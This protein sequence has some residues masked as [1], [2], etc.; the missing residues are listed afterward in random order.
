M[1]LLKQVHKLFAAGALLS[2]SSMILVVG[3]QIFSRFFLEITPHWTEEAARIFFIYSVA[4]GTGTA[5]NQGDFVRLDLV[6]KYLSPVSSRIL[7]F[8]TEIITIFFSIIL[9]TQSLYFIR[10]GMDEKSAA[11]QI[12]MSFIFLSITITGI[13]I[14]IFTLE[15]LYYTVKGTKSK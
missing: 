10:L 2:L 9:T 14:F 6:G 15:N 7:Q 8:F 4:F 5:I 1:R 12:P 3:V 11:L 13:A